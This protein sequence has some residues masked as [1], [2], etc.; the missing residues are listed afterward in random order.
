MWVLFALQI[1]PSMICIGFTIYNV[2]RNLNF[3]S[4]LKNTFSIFDIKD[5]FALWLGLFSAIAVIAIIVIGRKDIFGTISSLLLV[6]PYIMLGIATF[7]V[8]VRIRTP[9]VLTAIYIAFLIG[10]IWIIISQIYLI[11]KLTKVT[12]QLKA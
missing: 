2:L 12:K 1:I 4:S 9:A 7:C 11:V 6:A 10:V 8:P 3:S 5:G